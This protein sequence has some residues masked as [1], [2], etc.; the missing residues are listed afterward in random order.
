MLDL[1]KRGLVNYALLPV[2]GV[3][4]VLSGLR[5]FL[6]KIG[7]FAT[8]HFE[9]PIIVVGNITLGGTGKTPIVMAL[10]D[11]F[12]QQGRKVGVVSRGYGGQH[13]AGSLW[14]NAHTCPTQSG[15]E[16]LLIARQTQAVVMVN[17]NRALAV[18]DL[19]RRFELDLIISDDG[20][21]HYAMARTVEIV[22][23][24]NRRFGN[25]FLLPAGMLRELPAR[26]KT[27]DFVINN[28]VARAGEIALKLVPKWFVNVATG[29]RES[30]DFFAHQTCDGVA[31]IGNP[32]R[33][34]DTLKQLKIEVIA[35][36]FADHHPFCAQDL[37]FENPY[38]ILMT[39]KDYVKCAQFANAQMWYLQ[40]EAVFDADFFQQL[41]AKL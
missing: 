39:A 11:F 10:V 4:Y 27:V 20:L 2:A 1:T 29:E 37:A 16:P 7:W 22:A 15:D 18:A 19:L 28:G 3:F 14:V 5:R 24:D 13:R 32:A 40:V 36:P 30:V 25:G 9:V 33:F 38:P 41:S 35:H 34:F 31:G 6:Y 17:K 12:T 26:L 21:Q 23:L 8:H